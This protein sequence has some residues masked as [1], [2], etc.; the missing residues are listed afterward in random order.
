MAKKPKIVAAPKD[1]IL[2]VLVRTDMA[3]MKYGKGGAQIGHACNA[4][5][6]DMII[7]PLLR[8]DKPNKAVMEWRAQAGRFGTTLTLAVPGLDTMKAVVEAAQGLGYIAD[9]VVD[10]TYPYLVPNELVP[11]LDASLH[12]MPPRPAGREQ[13]VCFT[14]ETTTAYVFGLKPELDVLIGR[15]PLVSND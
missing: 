7:A 9:P 11:R 3:S 6:D 13:H 2:Y 15:F 10:P 14:E 8:G 12:T 1:W 4:L 5:T